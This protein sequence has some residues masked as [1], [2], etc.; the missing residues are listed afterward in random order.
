MSFALTQILSRIM[1]PS[2]NGFDISV[3]SVISANAIVDV[4]D[5]QPAE[6]AILRETIFIESA[7]SPVSS[8]SSA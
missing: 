3:V 8:L 5:V 2:L 4:S 7:L 1:P 6:L